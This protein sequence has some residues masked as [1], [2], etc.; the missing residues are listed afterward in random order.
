MKKR[1]L[2]IATILI[3]MSLHFIKANNYP[4]VDRTVKLEK[5]MPEGPSK[6]PALFPVIFNAYLSANQLSI[7]A[8]NYTANVLINIAGTAALSQGLNFGNSDMVVLDLSALPAG[9]YQIT[10]VTEGKG[11]FYGTFYL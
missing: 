4:K 10:V 1:I 9:E 5:E 3:M 6:A 7:Q 11:T 8:E 2:L